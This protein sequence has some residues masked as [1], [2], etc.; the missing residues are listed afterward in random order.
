[1]PRYIDANKIEFR[2]P[3]YTDEDGEVLIPLLALRHCIEQTPTAD[4]REN[5][6]AKWL[7]NSDG[8][9]PYCSACGYELPR[10]FDV[11]TDFCPGCGADMRSG[12]KMGSVE[13]EANE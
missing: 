8:Y 9:F 13:S 12:G 3:T 5:T 10:D 6:P 11:L 1:M 7:I 2:L 4:V